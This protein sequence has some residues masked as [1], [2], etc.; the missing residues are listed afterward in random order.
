MGETNQD[1]I[2]DTLGETANRSNRQATPIFLSRQLRCHNTLYVNNIFKADEENLSVH[3]E[4][5]AVES[6]FISKRLPTHAP[7]TS[8]ITCLN[9]SKDA[10]KILVGYR[11][12]YFRTFSSRTFLALPDYEPPAE[13]ANK[14]SITA[15]Y[16]SNQDGFFVIC[17]NMIVEYIYNQFEFELRFHACSKLQALLCDNSNPIFAV[18]RKGRF[19]NVSAVAPMLNGIRRSNGIERDFVLEH[20]YQIGRVEQFIKLDTMRSD[21]N[22]YLVQEKHNIAIL[23]LWNFPQ[24]EATLWVQRIGLACEPGTEVQ[25]LC[26]GYKYFYASLLGNNTISDRNVYY[27]TIDTIGQSSADMSIETVSGYVTR[28]D[29]SNDFLLVMTN[30]LH[31]EIFSAYMTSRLFDIEVGYPIRR[32]MIFKNN[33]VIATKEGFLIARNLTPGNSL[34]CLHCQNRFIEGSH[35]KICFHFIPTII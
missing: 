31:I 32:T 1:P 13:H 12:G 19:Y 20:F 22:L 35:W 4:A 3:N 29:M 28:L 10:T 16:D 23:N 26:S 14:N 30:S 15:I 5:F 8:V 11:K 18:D 2:I 33:L 9:L 25:V 21:V 34:C 6:K 7:R 17:N 27:N 24:Q